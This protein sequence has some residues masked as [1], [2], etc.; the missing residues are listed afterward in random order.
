MNYT[1]LPAIFT[2]GT[3]IGFSAGIFFC[4]LILFIRSKIASRTLAAS[5]LRPN[6][7]AVLARCAVDRKVFWL[8]TK[9]TLLLTEI[10][11]EV[12]RVRHS[13]GRDATEP[14]RATDALLLTRIV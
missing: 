2:G 14:I 5:D 6:E 8:T 1:K 12:E 7:A 3:H 11:P 9:I 13:S 10:T 4:G